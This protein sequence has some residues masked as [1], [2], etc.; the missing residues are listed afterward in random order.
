MNTKISQHIPILDSLR[1]FAAISVCLFHFVCTTT[2]YI[3][4]D[5]LLDFFSMGKYGVQL[6]FVI[7]GFVIPWSMYNSNFKSSDFFRFFIKRLVRLE[8]PYLLSLITVLVIIYARS[9]II[10]DSNTQV[11]PS[12]TQIF[13]HFGYLIPFFQDYKWLNDVYWTLAIEFQYYLF[14]AIIFPL[15]IKSKL[16]IRFTLYVLFIIASFTTTSKFLPHWL[17]FFSLG[18]ILFLLLANLISKK[19]YYITTSLL[20][21]FCIYKYPI[22]MTIFSLLPIISILFWKNKEIFGLDFLGKFS[23]SIYLFHPVLGAT[24]INIMSHHFKAPHEKLI[25]IA[26]G[27]II[28]ILSAWLIYI[29][30]EKPSKTWS[31][32]I[33][34]R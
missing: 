10:K 7:S 9:I 28:T 27:F 4:T 25:V 15:I 8:P 34:Y 32:K 26:I 2:G 24:F 19:E 13:L 22:A 16:Y 12:M 23:Y 1:A 17:P 18:I 29:F 20:V 31:S 3:K 33:K 14:I 5:W 21:A 11:H 6:F 30:I